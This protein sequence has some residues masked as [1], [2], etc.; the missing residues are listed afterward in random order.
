MKKHLGMIV[1]AVLVVFFMGLSTVAFVVDEPG[2]LVVV[3]RFGKI[4]RVL[5][6][7]DP[8]EGQAGLHFKWPYPVEEAISLDA[9]NFEFDD[10]HE[11]TA[12][13][14]KKNVVVTVFCCWR[15]GDA[16]QFSRTAKTPEAG[17]DAVRNILR[18]AKGAAVANHLLGELINTDRDKMKQDEIER[19][20]Q[21]ALAPQVARDYGIEI[22]RVG[23]KSLGLPKSVSETVI[24]TMKE[25]RGTKAADYENRGKAYAMAI[26]ERA[27]AASEKILAFAGS[28][29][30][31]IRTEGDVMAAS[32][33][34]RF[35]GNEDLAKFL[36]S[37][38]ALKT[39]LA[40][41]TVILLDESTLP[42]IKLFRMPPSNADIV[43]KPVITTQPV[44]PPLESSK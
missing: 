2:E 41:R 8:N 19:E 31:A 38:E 18:S 12:T 1:L 26:R 28:K 27:R 29:Q 5:S 39:E 44:L 42:M 17:Q 43:P 22:V 11:Q 37:L 24:N 20:M 16:A 34:S 33:Y 4:M 6:G 32:Y 3:K 9:R 13:R 40:S 15:I 25:E 30:Q 36:R 10:T 7:R 21:Q 35:A 14:D 23:I